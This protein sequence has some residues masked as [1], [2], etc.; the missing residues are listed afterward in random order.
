MLKRKN[1][2]DDAGKKE[3]KKYELEFTGKYLE[4]EDKTL[5]EELKLKKIESK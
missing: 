4:N 2:V 1:E 3:I 5:N